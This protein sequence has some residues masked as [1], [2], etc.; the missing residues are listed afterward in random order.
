MLRN[1]SDGLSPSGGV[2]RAWRRGCIT[3]LANPKVGAFYVALLPQFIPSGS[4]HILVG[5]LLATIHN[6]EGLAWFSLLIFGVNGGQSWIMKPWLQR[7]FN[8]IT[9]TVLIAFAS[10]LV[11]SEK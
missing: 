8:T 7:T 9:G 1:G 10:T 6:L 11:L 3:N 2:V 5:L 4:P